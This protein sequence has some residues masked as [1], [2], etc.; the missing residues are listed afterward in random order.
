MSVAGAVTNAGSDGKTLLH[1]AAMSGQTAVIA[2]LLAAGANPHA[3]CSSGETPLD[4]AG[5]WLDH[6]GNLPAA[7]GQSSGSSGIVF[8]DSPAPIVGG[9]GGGGGGGSGDPSLVYQGAPT[10]HPPWNE[11][12]I[13]AIYNKNNTPAGP[14]HSPGWPSPRGAGGGFMQVPSPATPTNFHAASCATAAAA[15]F[16]SPPPAP[17][18]PAPPVRSCAKEDAAGVAWLG[19]AQ[20]SAGGTTVEGQAGGEAVAGGAAAA[21][22][23]TAFYGQEHSPSPATKGRLWAERIEAGRKQPLC[24]VECV[25]YCAMKTPGGSQT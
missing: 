11:Q 19:V 23:N 24:R 17:T 16:A 14:V 2:E 8:E 6:N 13:A 4:L 3:R 10:D 20:T 9:G 22:A 25:S 1:C 7:P 15:A 12:A 5:R 18:P 21:A